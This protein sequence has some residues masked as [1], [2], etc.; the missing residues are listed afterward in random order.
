MGTTWRTG[1]GR[2]AVGSS[3]GN[4]SYRPSRGDGAVRRP[5]GRKDRPASQAGQRQA[6]KRR[7]LRIEGCQAA[8]FRLAD[9]EC[10][11]RGRVGRL[12]LAFQVQ[13]GQTVLH[14]DHLDH[15][16]CRAGNPYGSFGVI[17][18]ARQLGADRELEE[19]IDILDQRFVKSYFARRQVLAPRRRRL[20]PRRHSRRRAA[21]APAGRPRTRAPTL[22][23]ATESVKPIQRL[24]AVGEDQRGA[25]PGG[26]RKI[27]LAGAVG[28]LDVRAVQRSSRLVGRQD[29]VRRP[30][31]PAGIRTTS[32]SQTYSCQGIDDLALNRQKAL[33]FIG[34]TTGPP[35]LTARSYRPSASVRVRPTSGC[36][37]YANFD[38]GQRGTVRREDSA[39]QHRRPP[40]LQ[41]ALSA[42]NWRG[43]L[44][45][46]KEADADARLTG[47]GV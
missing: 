15:A 36:A 24:V 33:F 19:I 4:G 21:A 35:P 12:P 3:A 9:A 22:Y 7:V 40:S 42:P 8:A 28:V 34:K 44:P 30:A 17:A 37:G 43:A 39:A 5:Q 26:A 41:C 46:N 11:Q 18:R 31:R 14:A 16:P 25:K 23:S 10:G 13:L 2:G 1:C 6:P 27:G 47:A 45:A 38:A 29:P 32:G 20:R